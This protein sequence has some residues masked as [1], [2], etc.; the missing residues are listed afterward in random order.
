M[1][2]KDGG[3]NSGDSSV[4]Y[5]RMMDEKM[6]QINKE[7][8]FEDMLENE[9][10]KEPTSKSRAAQRSPNKETIGRQGSL[11]SAQS[12]TNDGISLADYK[13][14]KTKKDRK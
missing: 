7:L 11:L 9:L 2:F 5:T 4:E 3:E 14:A 8:K 10:V 13:Q 12:L 1:G 6:R